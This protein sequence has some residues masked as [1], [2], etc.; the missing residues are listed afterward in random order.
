QN[1]P[2]YLAQQPKATPTAKELARS[3]GVDLAQVDA[4]AG[5]RITGADVRAAAGGPAPAALARAPVAAVA[6]AEERVPLAGARAITAQRMLESSQSTAAFTLTTEVDASRLV[7]WREGLKA[8]ARSGERVPSYTDMLVRLVA[9]ALAEQPALNARL[10][11]AEIV[12][13]RQ[14]NIGIAVD[15]ERSLLVP[16]LRDAGSLTLAGIAAASADLIARA[17]GGQLLPDEM[18]GGTFTVTNLGVYDID[19]FTP[20][21]NVPE[22]AILGVGRIKDKAVVVDGVVVVKPMVVLSLTIDHRAVDG[23]P[24]ARFL[25]RVKG[26]I[27]EPLLAL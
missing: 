5:Q 20:I 23:A 24:G 13:S 4:A 10:E 12:R 3:L 15:T 21:I 27:E 11:G 17:R 16:V 1:G 18:K 6:A 19:A 22:V 14:A 9:T 7:A 26:L 8:R 2:H 25:H